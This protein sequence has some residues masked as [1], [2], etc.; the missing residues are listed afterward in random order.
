MFTRNLTSHYIVLPSFTDF[1]DFL[2]RFYYFSML[3]F[4]RLHVFFSEFVITIGN[5]SWTIGD[6]IGNTMTIFTDFSDFLGR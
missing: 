6:V 3:L 4:E 1:S 5:I 2:G